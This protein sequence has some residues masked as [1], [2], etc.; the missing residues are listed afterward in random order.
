MEPRDFNPIENELRIFNPWPS[1]GTDVM[2]PSKDVAFSVRGQL[3]A[4]IRRLAIAYNGSWKSALLAALCKRELGGE[5]V[6]LLV[7]V[8]RLMT[9]QDLMVARKTAAGLELPLQ[10]VGMESGLPPEVAQ[11]NQLRCYNCKKNMLARLQAVAGTYGFKTLADALCADD[12]TSKPMSFQAAEETGVVHPL[13]SFHAADLKQF[14][15]TIMLPPG[16]GRLQGCL[17][18]RINENLPITPERLAQVE[19]TE[20]QIAQLGLPDCLV[21]HFGQYA[22]IEVPEDD[23]DTANF[24]YEK[25]LRLAT[26]NGFLSISIQ[27]RPR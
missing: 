3:G 10:T 11:N 25:I 16:L 20:R 5:N 17:A 14:S 24:L 15:K 1:A 12:A 21:R 7:F 13:G 23:F 9:A 27:K 19:N 8:S 4:D 2:Q 26:S 22:Q 18:V 6:I